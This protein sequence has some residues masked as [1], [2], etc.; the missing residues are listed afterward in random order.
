MKTKLAPSIEPD[1]EP[2]RERRRKARV[3]LSC[4]ILVRPLEPEPEYFESI[5]LTHNSC[6]DGLSFETDNA[7]YCQR[8]R[9]LVTFPYS[10]HPCAINQDYIAEVVRRKALPDGRYSV[11]VRFLTTAKLSIPPTSKLRSS[12]VWNALWQ[13]ARVDTNATKLDCAG[14]ANRSG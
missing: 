9:L 3:K 8:M 2:V 7:L 6:R 5:V 10:R 1:F 11:A 14:L 12:N 13:R 4:F